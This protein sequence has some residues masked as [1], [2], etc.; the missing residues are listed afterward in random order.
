M[1]F[2]A[3]IFISSQSAKSLIG[4]EFLK[5]FSGEDKLVD[6]QGHGTHVA[7][8]IGSATWGVAK[9]TKLFAV[10]VLDSSGSGS[11]SAVIAGIQ[12]VLQ[13]AQL[14]K[15]ECP[16]GIV[17]NMSLG[18]NKNLAINA[19]VSPEPHMEDA[20]QKEN[21]RSKLEKINTSID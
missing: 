3:V 8:T 12:Y 17:S 5:D 19:A 11:N 9:K 20:F 10:K 18:G 15:D 14:R 16:K 7:G 1:S 21:T 4:A 2:P 6:G 13:D